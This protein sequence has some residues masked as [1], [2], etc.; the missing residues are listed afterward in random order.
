[1]SITLTGVKNGKIL[2]S[3]C[4]L[5]LG[6]LRSGLS[7][8]VFASYEGIMAAIA[9]RLSVLRVARIINCALD[10]CRLFAVEITVNTYCLHNKVRTRFQLRRLVEFCDQW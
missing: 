5:A 7:C 2:T 4:A 6:G 8:G 1:M 10:A 3:V 9:D